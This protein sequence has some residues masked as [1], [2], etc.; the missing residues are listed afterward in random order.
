MGPDSYPI[1]PNHQLA[2]FQHGPISE[3]SI[4]DYPMFTDTLQGTSSPG[5]ATY[6][7]SGMA[8]TLGP[9]LTWG[10]DFGEYVDGH[11]Q[12]YLRGPVQ[13][14]TAANSADIQVSSMLPDDFL[15]H[16]QWPTSPSTPSMGATTPTFSS[17]AVSQFSESLGEPGRQSNG[18]PPGNTPC[19]PSFVAQHLAQEQPSP[20]F[21]FSDLIHTADDRMDVI[22]FLEFKRH[23]NSRGFDKVLAHMGKQIVPIDAAS[24]PQSKKRK[25]R[26]SPDTTPRPTKTRASAALS[27][28]SPMSR[29]PSRTLATTDQWW[30]RLLRLR[31][32]DV[33][34]SLSESDKESLRH[35][36]FFLQ[37]L[38]TINVATANLATTNP[39]TTNLAPLQATAATAIGRKILFTFR[40]ENDAFRADVMRMAMRLFFSLVG[41]GSS[42]N[43]VSSLTTI[44][45]GASGSSSEC[46]MFKISDTQLQAL[47]E[48]LKAYLPPD[49]KNGEQFVKVFNKWRDEGSRYAFI[50]KRLGLGSLILL[51]NPLKKI[52]GCTKGG[53]RS[54]ISHITLRHLQTIGY[55]RH[56]SETG[57]E[58]LMTEI[59]WT[60]CEGIERVGPREGQRS[61]P[62][63]E[64]LI[65]AGQDDEYGD[66]VCRGAG[67][68]GEQQ[69]EE[70]FNF[71]LGECLVVYC[72]LY[73]THDHSLG[74]YFES[75]R[76]ERDG[77]LPNAD[78]AQMHGCCCVT[79]AA[80]PLCTNHVSILV[81]RPAI[82]A[83]H[84]PIE[85]EDEYE[86]ALAEIQE[87]LQAMTWTDE[88]PQ[89]EWPSASVETKTGTSGLELVRQKIIEARR[90]LAQMGRSQMDE[91]WFF[92][93]DN[94]RDTRPLPCV[95]RFE[96]DTLIII[97]D[98]TKNIPRRKI[99]MKTVSFIHGLQ[100]TKKCKESCCPGQ[101]PRQANSQVL[102]PAEPTN[103][104]ASRA[105]EPAAIPVKTVWIR[106]PAEDAY[107]SHRDEETAQQ[108][109]SQLLQVW[110]G[111]LS[112]A[113]S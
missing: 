31:Q 72:I 21:N 22:L 104:P 52:W 65:G 108:L 84:S 96:Q 47:Y 38:A 109:E 46:R 61:F 32:S 53:D 42:Y 30:N 95:L 100:P 75:L 55:P 60:L 29:T 69:H 88:S 74:S 17:R 89:P 80:S 103:L 107:I 63:F 76:L 15:H 16:N 48:D 24:M 5:N 59:M 54:G 64:T 41:Q 39:S 10:E 45:G 62:G 6:I 49:V 105:Q 94:R 26:A 4:T 77:E 81:P 113:G 11:A 92:A 112:S 99:D 36:S 2:P 9:Q 73:T 79:T 33:L 14:S 93:P 56:A 20:L 58:T 101:D 83:A 102:L 68:E 85:L 91:S 1:A 28:A 25:R 98:Q 19:P 3:H 34:L 44:V 18:T 67:G 35:A 90:R 57:A 50:A 51:R 110:A 87:R 23:G 78:G 43:S 111:V 70:Y 82:A 97:V 8:L 12:P 86:P 71:D 7:D 13:P 66:P 40:L 37:G 27:V 106:T